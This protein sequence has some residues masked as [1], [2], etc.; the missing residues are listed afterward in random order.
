MWS[1]RLLCFAKRTNHVEKNMKSLAGSGTCSAQFLEAMEDIGDAWSAKRVKDLL[2][3]AVVDNEAGGAE[4]GEM[5]GDGRD[6]GAD[7]GGEI[8][9][10]AFA[11]GKLV[12][13]EEAAGMAQGLEDIGAGA[14]FAGGTFGP[15]CYCSHTWQNGI[16]EKWCQW[17]FMHKRRLRAMEG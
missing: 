1:E 16:M 12:D 7:E 3:T 4:D 13:D 9:D 14:I 2:A 10:A 8:R 17:G 5:I 11:A 15:G 6:I